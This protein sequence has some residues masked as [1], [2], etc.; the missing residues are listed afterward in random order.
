MKIDKLNCC[1]KSILSIFLD[2]TI[3]N[4]SPPMLFFWHKLDSTVEETRPRVA[5]DQHTQE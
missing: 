3:Y 4:G 1:V 2:L 5:T